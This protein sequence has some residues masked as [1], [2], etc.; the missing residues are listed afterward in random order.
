MESDRIAMHL[1][2]RASLYINRG[3][4][5]RGTA[6]KRRKLN[7]STTERRLKNKPAN[8]YPTAGGKW[9]LGEG[10]KATKEIEAYLAYEDE[11]GPRSVS[12]TVGE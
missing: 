7:V 4:A 3:L 5:G 6:S 11:L 8:I 12:L 2:P 9:P 10:A 1:P